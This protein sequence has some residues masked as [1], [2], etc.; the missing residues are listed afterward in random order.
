VT[1]SNNEVEKHS[2]TGWNNMCRYNTPFKG[3]HTIIIHLIEK[4][5]AMFIGLT[6]KDNI[7]ETG[8]FETVGL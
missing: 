1:F 7:S 6:H 5:E 2:S 4:C 3:K 8:Y